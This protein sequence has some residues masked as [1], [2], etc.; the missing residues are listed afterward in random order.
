MAIVDPFVP[1]TP[2]GDSGSGSNDSGSSSTNNSS[3]LSGYRFKKSC[4]Q[5]F[6]CSN[7]SSL[8]EYLNKYSVATEDDYV[9]LSNICI[10]DGLSSS[11]KDELAER[12][13]DKYS[14][15]DKPITFVSKSDFDARDIEDDKSIPGYLKIPGFLADD[16]SFDIALNNTYPTGSTVIELASSDTYYYILSNLTDEKLYI[17]VYDIETNSLIQDADT[18]NL[19]NVWIL[20]SDQSGTVYVPQVA[21]K[22]YPRKL[23]IWG[24]AGGGAGST[25]DGLTSGGGGGSGACF[26]GII[27]ITDGRL[28]SIYVGTGGKSS[29]KSKKGP[30]GSD[31]YI[32]EFDQGSLSSRYIAYAHGGA[33]G[34]GDDDV[35]PGG[36]GGV[37]DPNRSKLDAG[38]V[39]Y[40][41]LTQDR[42]ARKIIYEQG[43][44]GGDRHE[45][46]SGKS[47]FD[48]WK[49]LFSDNFTCYCNKHITPTDKT[50]GSGGSGIGG[51]G[52]GASLFGN[53]GAATYGN[54]GDGTLGSGGGGKIY[55]GSNGSADARAGHGGDGFVYIIL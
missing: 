9:D 28:F 52:G 43:A 10:R 50:G 48:D 55:H 34:G 46:G 15:S 45:S 30:D 26:G 40:P 16:T 22:D 27:D 32:V 42:W 5:D 11:F 41:A 47:G 12:F 13:V 38:I 2:G 49:I 37:C 1:V 33:G 17:Q 51:G 18:L 35:K 4:V 24:Q 39:V 6:Y 7:C 44:K 19:I 31:T 21:V 36:S 23:A 3:N 8:D 14:I 53:G 25:G 20:S 54:S 29:P